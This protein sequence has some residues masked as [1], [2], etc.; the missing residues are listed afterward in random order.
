MW[1]YQSPIGTMRIRSEKERYILWI[2]DTRIGSYS[3]A[4][5]A[6]DDVTLFA[7]GYDG[8]DNLH[9]SVT[10]PSGIEEW[11]YSQKHS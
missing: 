5:K 4:E 6:A 2:G 1:S 10:P 7:T 8:W 9:S 11:S 3:T